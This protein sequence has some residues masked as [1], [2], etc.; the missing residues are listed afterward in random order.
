MTTACDP[1]VALAEARRRYRSLLGGSDDGIDVGEER[2]RGFLDGVSWIIESLE[3]NGLKMGT[4]YYMRQRT[5]YRTTVIHEGGEDGP[6]VSVDREYRECH[7]C[8]LSWGWLPLMAYDPESTLGISFRS[9]RQ[10]EDY[11]DTHPEVVICDEYGD[12]YTREDFSDRVR[13]WGHEIGCPKGSNPLRHDDLMSFSDD[14]GFEFY[15]GE[16]S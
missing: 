10:I 7:L 14:E 11:A 4:N 12:E 8:K 16:F 6:V 2:V 3:R 15:S 9:L 5:P 1:S 13:R